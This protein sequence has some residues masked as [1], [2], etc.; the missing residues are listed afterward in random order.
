MVLVLYR[1]VTLSAPQTGDRRGVTW[2]GTQYDTSLEGPAMNEGPPGR[3]PSPRWGKEKNEGW[4]ELLRE[5]DVP[6]F[7]S[8]H[9]WYTQR[10][11]AD[12]VSPHVIVTN[13]QLRNCTG[14]IRS[15][16]ELCTPTPLYESKTGRC[17]PRSS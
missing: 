6:V 15:P 11:R 10:A 5:E 14:I 4:C 8:L 2:Q 16:R 17:R 7:E 1:L 9:A 13:A 12:A 3:A